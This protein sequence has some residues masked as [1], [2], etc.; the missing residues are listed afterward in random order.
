MIV[1]L[2]SI[3]FSRFASF[4]DSRC[5]YFA[6]VINKPTEDTRRMERVVIIRHCVADSCKDMISKE[7]MN[8]AP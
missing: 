8:P 7:L 4:F 6:N 1:A 3:P 5:R 2:E